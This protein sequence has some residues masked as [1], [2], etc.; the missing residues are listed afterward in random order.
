MKRDLSGISPSDKAIDKLFKLLTIKQNE[1]KKLINRIEEV[2][3]LLLKGKVDE[4]L[5]II[6]KGD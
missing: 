3:K 1:N 4:A 6:V 5:Q 2:K